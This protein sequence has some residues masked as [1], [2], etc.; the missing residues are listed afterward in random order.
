MFRRSARSSGRTGSQEQPPRCL[1]IRI[2]FLRQENTI[3]P[4]E[5][6]FP[7]DGDLPYKCFMAN[8]LQEFP[9]MKHRGSMGRARLAD[10]RGTCVAGVE[11][12]E[13]DTTPRWSTLARTES[14][15]D[16]MGGNSRE[17][18]RLALRVLTTLGDTGSYNPEDA[19][20]LRSVAG[21]LHEFG[22]PLDELA[23]LVVHRERQALATLSSG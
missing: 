1:Q 14:A 22:K 16:Q 21:D 5:A 3:D 15:P 20:A 9:W 6:V 19:M 12:K 10:T 23:C 8:T 18:I 11:M 13:S 7:P 4:S 2:P 17:I